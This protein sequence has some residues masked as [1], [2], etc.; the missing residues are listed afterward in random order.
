ME[1]SLIMLASCVQILN[2]AQQRRTV[3]I[4][5]L[6]LEIGP[7]RFFS[8]WFF[9]WDPLFALGGPKGGVVSQ[10]QIDAAVELAIFNDLSTPTANQIVFLLP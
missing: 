4:G 3:E 9:S 5:K 6:A 8:Y 10:M 7:G 1:K 2:Q